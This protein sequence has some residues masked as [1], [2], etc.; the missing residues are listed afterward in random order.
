MDA[1]NDTVEALVETSPGGRP[2]KSD[3][4]WYDPS[5]YAGNI[6]WSMEPILDGTWDQVTLS[7]CSSAALNWVMASRLWSGD[8]NGL[9]GTPGEANCQY[10]AAGSS[11]A[12]NGSVAGVMASPSH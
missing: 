8:T 1:V 2:T 4:G 10:G 6:P 5:A 7:S 12:W 3:S 11:N 9:A